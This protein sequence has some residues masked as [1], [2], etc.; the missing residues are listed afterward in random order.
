MVS[1]T[2]QTRN[3]RSAKQKKAGRK[4]K[5]KLVNEGSTKSQEQLFG[6]KEPEE[7][8]KENK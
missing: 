1:A 7:S 6:S 8:T 2:S 5:N 4:R 3:I